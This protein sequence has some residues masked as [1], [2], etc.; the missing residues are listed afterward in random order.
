MPQMMST[1]HSF[2]AAE[3]KIRLRRQNVLFQMN[4]YASG[5]IA[6]NSPIGDF[7]ITEATTEIV[8]PTLRKRIAQ[9]DDPVLILLDL[10]G[11]I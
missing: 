7:Y 9:K 8:S 6:A 3:Q 4:L 1:L 2:V 10:L 11:P 5:G